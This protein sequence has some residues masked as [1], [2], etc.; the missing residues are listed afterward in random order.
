MDENFVNQ[1]GFLSFPKSLLRPHF[2][3][4][5]CA[6]VIFQPKGAFGHFLENFQNLTKKWRFFGARSPL[7]T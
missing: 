7:K 3:Q 1:I 6:A 2:D 5:I 4:I